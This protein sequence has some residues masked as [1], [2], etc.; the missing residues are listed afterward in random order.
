VF[1]ALVRLF[2]EN[3]WCLGLTRLHRRLTAN[4]RCL[5]VPKQSQILRVS[6]DFVADER[7]VS[8]TAHEASALGGVITH[9]ELSRVVLQG[10]GAA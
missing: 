10:K 1:A 3:H 6:H 4:Q 2:I 7:R 8:Y 5:S 9:E